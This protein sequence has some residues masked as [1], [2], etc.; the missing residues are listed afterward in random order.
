[1]PIVFTLEWKRVSSRRGHAPVIAEQISE[2]S[3]KQLVHLA[4]ELQALM[5]SPIVI[6]HVEV[7]FGDPGE[8]Q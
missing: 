1:M 7:L 2:E 6:R 8:R 4:A 3:S 5:I